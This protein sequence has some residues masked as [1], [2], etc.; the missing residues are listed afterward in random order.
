VC[1]ACNTGARWIFTPFALGE[2]AGVRGQLA[3][4]VRGALTT[5]PPR[6]WEQARGEAKIAA[7]AAVD[8]GGLGDL[9]IE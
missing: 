1:I 8:L 2:R 4:T 3:A 6:P 9:F 5:C 7:N